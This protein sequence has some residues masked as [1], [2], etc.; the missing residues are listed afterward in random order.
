MK[1]YT[2]NELVAKL[3]NVSKETPLGGDAKICIDDVERNL[4]ADGPLESLDV[5]YDAENGYVTIFC[6]RFTPG[7]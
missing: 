5:A 7:N 1:T 2:I 3:V 4:G 6:D